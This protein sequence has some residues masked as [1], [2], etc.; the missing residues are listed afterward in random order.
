M[1]AY[2]PVVWYMVE[3]GTAGQKI[4]CVFTLYG[5]RRVEYNLLVNKLC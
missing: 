3:K 2:Q 4:G 1:A 5:E